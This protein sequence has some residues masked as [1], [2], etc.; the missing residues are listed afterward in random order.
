MYDLSRQAGNW[1]PRTRYVEVYSNY[2]GGELT[3]NDYVGVY[4]L[5][6][7]IKRDDNRVDIAELTPTQNSEPDITGGYILQI[8]EA[9]PND[10]SWDTSRGYPIGE[11]S[12]H[13]CRA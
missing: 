10:A 11:Q 6:E 5:M 2:D 1:A 12:V 9:E 13:P 3:D 8:D 7:V 4:V